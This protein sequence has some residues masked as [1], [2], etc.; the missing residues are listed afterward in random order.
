MCFSEVCVYTLVKLY[1]L[2]MISE[3]L[4][5]F[6]FFYMK[7]SHFLQAQIKA[8]FWIKIILYKPIES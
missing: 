8:M 2:T 6:I 7:M 5:M 3:I 4:F 1:N